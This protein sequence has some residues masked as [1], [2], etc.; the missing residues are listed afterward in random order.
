VSEGGIKAMGMELFSQV[1]SLFSA[2]DKRGKRSHAS[3]NVRLGNS[4]SR[5]FKEAVRAPFDSSSPQAFLEKTK[6]KKRLLAFMVDCE[7]MH[8]TGNTYAM[9]NDNGSKQHHYY[10]GLGYVTKCVNQ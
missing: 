10:C 8:R 6:K 4:W 3:S 7:S 1:S 9:Y 5:R 2:R